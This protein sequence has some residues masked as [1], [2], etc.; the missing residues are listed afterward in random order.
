M[1]IRI[2]T[3]IIS[4]SLFS[5][6]LLKWTLKHT[7]FLTGGWQ[8]LLLHCDKYRMAMVLLQHLQWASDYTSDT[9]HRV[10]T[11][12]TVILRRSDTPKPQ[13]ISAALFPLTILRLLGRCI[14]LVF[15]TTSILNITQ[16]AKTTPDGVGK[17]LRE[18]AT[19]RFQRS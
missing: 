1:N 7:D 10:F 18:R 17:F 14:V 6:C 11:A 9:L 16:N 2:G 15:N 12:E 8:C 4:V 19:Q 3:T 5:T 13:K